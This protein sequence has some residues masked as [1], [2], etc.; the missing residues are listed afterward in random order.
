VKDLAQLFEQAGM[1]PAQAT[2]EAHACIMCLFALFSDDDDAQTT[3]T[4]EGLRT[5]S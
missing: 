1:E 4:T 2:D 5:A 3:T